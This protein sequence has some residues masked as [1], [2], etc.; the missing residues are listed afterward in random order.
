MTTS[1]CSN[2]L[3]KTHEIKGTIHEKLTV[4]IDVFVTELVFNN[5]VYVLYVSPFTNVPQGLS[6]R[7]NSIVETLPHQ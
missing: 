1:F 3:G 4:V 7:H 5:F 6:I 2:Y